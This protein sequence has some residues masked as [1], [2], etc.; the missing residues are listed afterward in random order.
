RSELLAPRRCRWFLGSER[1]RRPAQILRAPTALMNHHPVPQGQLVPSREPKRSSLDDRRA[2]IMHSIVPDIRMN[3]SSSM[4]R[5]VGYVTLSTPA[6]PTCRMS[7]PA[8]ILEA[9]R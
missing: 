5:P 3:C 9:V 2:E 6:G 7:P 8:G 4:R 1:I